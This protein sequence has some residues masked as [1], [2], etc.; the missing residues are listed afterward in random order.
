VPVGGVLIGVGEREQFRLSKK[1]ADERE[2]RRV[3]LL[4]EAVRQEHARVAVRLVTEVLPWR[5]QVSMK[6][7]AVQRAFCIIE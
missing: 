5:R 3:S 1:F 4:V 2:A 7:A 6:R